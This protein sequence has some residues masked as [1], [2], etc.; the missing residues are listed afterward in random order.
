MEYSRK[1]EQ[2]ALKFA[3]LKL[4]RAIPAAIVTWNASD[5]D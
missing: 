5:Y 3:C 1:H 2:E 4:K